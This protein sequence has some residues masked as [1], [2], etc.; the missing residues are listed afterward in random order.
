MSEPDL[1]RRYAETQAATR[2][3][4]EE[5]QERVAAL[6]PSGTSLPERIGRSLSPAQR[7]MLTRAFHV[8]E[9]G[10]T[11]VVVRSGI[12]TGGNYR[13]LRALADAGLVTDIRAYGKPTHPTALAQG[14]LTEL[15]VEVR[16]T[17]T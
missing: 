14:R 2:E 7:L 5:D 4:T 13:T 1:G 12:D 9:H 11:S 17:L 8:T 3:L 15:G 16:A 10:T 6:L